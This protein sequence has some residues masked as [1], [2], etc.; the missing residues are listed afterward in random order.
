MS[1]KHYFPDSF[2]RC[3]RR[4]PIRS[5]PRPPPQAPSVAA[6]VAQGVSTVRVVLEQE[7][8]AV[9]QEGD[10][11]LPLCSHDSD[12]PTTLPFKMTFKTHTHT[13][14]SGYRDVENK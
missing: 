4:L 9:M 1:A 7:E 12:L 2:C 10:P 11:P 8:G 5:P 6:V 3:P 13:P 14:S